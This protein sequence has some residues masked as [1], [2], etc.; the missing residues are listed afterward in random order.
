M[1]FAVYSAPL[2]SPALFG[3]QFFERHEALQDANSCRRAGD[4]TDSLCSIE[5]HSPNTTEE[6]D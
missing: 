6:F 4:H 3:A 1:Q 2:H 5:A